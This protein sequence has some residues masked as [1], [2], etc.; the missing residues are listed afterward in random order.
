MGNDDAYV[1]EDDDSISIQ[2]VDSNPDSTTKKN[3]RVR[4]FNALAYGLEDSIEGRTFEWMDSKYV[5]LL[6]LSTYST[7]MGPKVSFV[8]KNEDMYNEKMEA[9]K[10]KY[11]H[12]NADSDDDE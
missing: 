6:Q 1:H 11:G 12:H 3:P 10:E 4:M 2:S 9:N 5:H 7:V 8:W